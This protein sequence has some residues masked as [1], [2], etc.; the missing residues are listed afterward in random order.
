[1]PAPT[2]LFG[3]FDRHNFGDLLFPHMAATPTGASLAAETMTRGKCHSGLRH[4]P[5]SHRR[6]AIHHHAHRRARSRIGQNRMPKGS[7]C[8]KEWGTARRRA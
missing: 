3:A 8:R 5:C 7:V 2:I 6:R 4:Q 1:M